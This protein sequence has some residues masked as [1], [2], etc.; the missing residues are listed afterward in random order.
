MCEH[1]YICIYR[2]EYK[3]ILYCNKCAN[4]EELM[5]NDK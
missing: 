2:D 1:D 4:I 5:K 3:I